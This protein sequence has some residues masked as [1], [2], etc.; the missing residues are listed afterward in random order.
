[1]GTFRKAKP[2]CSVL[3]I[4]LVIFLA[5]SCQMLG[6]ANPFSSGADNFDRARRALDSGEHDVALMNAAA[7]IN[8]DEKHWPSYK[9]IVENYEGS[10]AK[11]NARL[12]ELDEKEQTAEV[13]QEKVAILRNMYWFVRYVSRMPGDQPDSRVIERGKDSVTVALTDYE[14]PLA[15]AREQGYAI[16]F[17]QASVLIEAGEY[18]EAI[19]ALQV[20]TRSFVQGAEERE[21]AEITIAGFLVESATPLVGALSME[22]LEA[23]TQILIAAAR[24]EETEEVTALTAELN[25]KA[26]DVL[27]AA[28]ERA[29][30]RNNV[31]ALEE[32]LGIAVK[33]RNY[34]DDND[35][36][37]PGIY[38]YAQRLADLYYG[39]ARGAA[40]TFDGSSS[41]KWDAENL[42]LRYVAFVQGWPS[43]TG[44]E[45]SIE[46]FAEFI[47]S[48]RTVVHVVL[49][50]AHAAS[51]D[52]VLPALKSVLENQRGKVMW[53][54]TS[55]NRELADQ[56]VRH[57]RGSGR[58]W[59][60]NQ[61]E[62]E[63]LIYPDSSNTF[64]NEVNKLTTASSLDEARQFNI[65]FLVKIS[66]DASAGNTRSTQRS[67]VKQISAYLN[68][69]G[70]AH[71]DANNSKV[72]G[73]HAARVL[74]ENTGTMDTFN[75]KLQEDGVR[76]FWRN[77]SVNHRYQA[78]VAPVT[79]NYTL[80]VIRVSDGRSVYST[81]VTHRD[82]AKSDE[83]LV[84]VDTDVSAIRSLLEQQV[85]E[86]PTSFQPS[87]GRIEH[88]GFRQLNFAPVANAI[89]RS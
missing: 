37:N 80:E 23:A 32:A 28:A 68:M 36:V 63:R 44:H 25:S 2:F 27:F 54:Y 83:V 43:V 77:E 70:S 34:V 81:R 21:A 46:K 33:A 15:E 59:S 9:F 24:F 62:A 13:L 35:Q 40:R 6:I 71:L 72:N 4:L 87:T 73:W 52:S 79:V 26:P 78:L 69:D 30:R 48:S 89:G 16:A 88:A 20:I 38:P 60:N 82:E 76:E 18:E 75:Q 66:A 56:R 53:M 67:E 3:A 42:F 51:R 86:A 12:A 64:H 17:A 74:A 57:F 84:G 58:W 61:Q 55:E 19:E 29:A 85:R 14:T 7:A 47:E 65:D 50:P 5:S 41:S 31:D 1:M 49:D 45:D 22:N 10:L 8:R 11:V 39:E